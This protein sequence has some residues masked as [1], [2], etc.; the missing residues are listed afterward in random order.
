MILWSG[1]KEMGAPPEQ[2]RKGVGKSILCDHGIIISAGIKLLFFVVDDVV[3]PR[4]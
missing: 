4:G 3:D 1:G 2:L